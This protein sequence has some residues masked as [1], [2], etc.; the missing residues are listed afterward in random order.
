MTALEIVVVGPDAPRRA[1]LVAA[2]RQAGYRAVGIDRL[3]DAASP[4]PGGAPDI[5]AIDLH[6]PGLDLPRLRQ[7]LAP[8]SPPGPE[9]LDAVE[10]RHI[11]AT[12]EHTG[13]NRR[14]AALLLGISRST[15]LNKIRRYG[16]EPPAR[17]APR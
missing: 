4:M 15:L 1:S 13:G 14:Q 6:D 12:L 11:A 9:A 5:L 2:L 16:I 8:A 3:G 10:R 7:A 17:S